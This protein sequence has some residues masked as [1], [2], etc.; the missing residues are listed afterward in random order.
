M[1]GLKSTRYEIHYGL[2]GEMQ[3]QKPGKCMFGNTESFMLSN[4]L[5]GMTPGIFSCLADFCRSVS[6]EIK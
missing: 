1:S 6:G 2:G 4:S 5:T 3:F